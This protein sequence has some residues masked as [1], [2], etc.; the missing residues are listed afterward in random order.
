[1]NDL[2]LSHQCPQC[3]APVELTETDRIFACPFCQIRLFIHAAGPLN[4]YLPPR[5]RGAGTLFYVPY[6]RIRGNAYVLT[7]EELLHKILDSSLAAADVPSAPTSL[8]LRAQ[9]LAMRLVEPDTDG[10][11]MPPALPYA[12]FTSQLISALP[13][14]DMP[15][16]PRLTACVGDTI[17]LVYQPLYQASRLVDGIT[18]EELGP[19][20]IDTAKLAPP[21]CDLR[22]TPTMCP[23]C[24][25]DLE[26]DKQSLVQT[27]P[28]CDTVW[29][30]REA[31]VVAVTAHF[32]PAQTSASL[33]LPFWSLRVRASG[34]K[35]DTWADL[36]R[37]T[38]L[39]RP[40][41]PWME[42]TPFSFRVPAF[43][44]RPELYL[45]LSARVS[46]YQPA[47][48]PQEILPR[49]P[50]HPVTLSGL[51]AA[52]SLPVVL[53]RLAPARKHLFEHIR[54]GRLHASEARLEY[55]PFGE[56]HGELVQP[57]MNLAIQKNALHWSTTL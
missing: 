46:L 9:T 23:Q 10:L 11:F 30:P 18:G 57:D 43:K 16:G 55:V 33:F 5:Y 26:G 50:L 52:R 4:Y 37:L 14:L 48:T 15:S 53:G 54:G 20:A 2:S 35:L 34:F 56:E 25:W 47:T 1:M 21:S 8:G 44:I 45:N 51:E 29:Q 22:F 31:E 49:I 28:H 13:G 38:N 41:L 36:I 17:S 24:G 39:P 7:Q 42:A 3:G 27:C 32:L 12:Q 6:W 40:I 19:A